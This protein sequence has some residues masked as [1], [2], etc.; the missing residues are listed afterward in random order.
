MS[1]KRTEAMQRTLERIAREFLHLDTLEPARLDSVD[2]KEHCVEAIGE[3]L[4]WAYVKGY[5]ARAMEDGK[6]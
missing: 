3:A 5:E 4:K 2:C 1:G 6:P